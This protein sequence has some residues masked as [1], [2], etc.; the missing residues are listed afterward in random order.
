L[1]LPAVGRHHDLWLHILHLLP[2]RQV[3]WADCRDERL[4]AH[5]W[6]ISILFPSTTKILGPGVNFQCRDIQ[7]QNRWNPA[8]H[9]DNIVSIKALLQHSEANSWQE[10]VYIQYLDYNAKQTLTVDCISAINDCVRPND[11]H[12]SR[13]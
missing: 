8:T 9:L 1:V 7:L 10:S 4:G 12:L 2:A 5:E 13:P 11:R 6:R 3:P